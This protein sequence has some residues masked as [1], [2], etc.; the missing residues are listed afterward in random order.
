[1]IK[2]SFIGLTE[3]KLKCDLVEPGPKEPEAIPIP[4]RLILLLNEPLDSTKEILVKK[5]DM[6]KKGERIF[7]YKESKE[8]VSAPVS[9]TIT[10][11]APFT[12]DFGELATYLVVET[13]AK[14]DIDKSFT[15]S[16]SIPDIQ[17]ANSYLR[18]IAGNPPLKLL[19][20]A[21]DGAKSNGINIKKIIISGIDQDILCT[22]RQFVLT[23]FRDELSKSVAFLKQLTGINDI[24]IVMPDA[25]ATLSAFNGMNIVKISSDYVDSLSPMVMDKYLGIP[26]IPNKS[27]EELGVCFISIE[28]L[29]SLVKSYSEKR[30]VYEKIITIID[31]KGKKSRV[32]ATIGTPIHRIFTKIGV[33]TAEKDRIIIGG[34]L[35]GV[36]AYTL[37]Y[38]VTPDMD[39]LMVQD[40]S[41]IPTIS[42][43]PCI[44][45]GKCVRICPANVPVN[46][47]VR[48][49]EANLYQDAAD[50][51]DLFSC[52][53]C[54]LC[55]YV[56]SAKIPIFQ[57]IRLGKHEL[58]KIELD[59]I[60]EAENV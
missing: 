42:D 45:C 26:F 7:L 25:L 31:K 55:S 17:T 20:E 9:G 30:P 33:E 57:Y 22:T 47:L 35:K 39:T 50:S 59:M 29:F 36:A 49:L 15:E 14:Q 40:S 16:I 10:T 24:S 41:I 27:C 54:G 28:A 1:M 18:G 3:P 46:V 6:V 11:V 58:N 44:N 19:A 4:P 12:G 51:Y 52:I 5:G 43:Y 32:S 2:R 53:E 8:Y 21:A 56:C 60:K 13:N 23:R 37:Y 38:P 34:P 48:Y